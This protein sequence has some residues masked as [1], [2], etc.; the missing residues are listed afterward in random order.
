MRSLMR[1]ASSLTEFASARA[2]GDAQRIEIA[3][4]RR[5]AAGDGRQRRAQIMR[6]RGQQGVAD[7]LGF[8]AHLGRLG[9]RGEIGALERQ[10]DLAAKVSSS[11]NCSGRVT[12]RGIVRQHRQHAEYAL[13]PEQRQVQSRARR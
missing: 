7:R 4:E 1:V 11:R 6:D 12:R 5:G 9:V 8:G 3:G 2:V 13:A 10:P